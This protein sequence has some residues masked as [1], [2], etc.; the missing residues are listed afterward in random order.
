MPEKVRVH[1][2]IT[3]GGQSFNTIPDYSSS[4]EIGIR[5]LT[6][7][8]VVM[9][10]SEKFRRVV[11]AGALATGCEFLIEADGANGRGSC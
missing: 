7:E 10:V 5:A 2:I 11:E 9:S 1:G 4:A 3:N 8:E 6:M